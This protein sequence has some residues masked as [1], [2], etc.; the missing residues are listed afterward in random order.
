MSPSLVKMIPDPEPID[1]DRGAASEPVD[2]IS[3]IFTTDGSTTWATASIDADLFAR[4]PTGSE[5]SG[6]LVDGAP[7]AMV[8][9]G[10]SR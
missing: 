10:S 2:A 9:S 8:V 5:T 6:V 4:A 7:A 3:S 1:L